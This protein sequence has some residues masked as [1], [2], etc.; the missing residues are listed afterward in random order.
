MMV[1]MAVTVTVLVMGV[2]MAAGGAVRVVHRVGYLQQG[3]ATHGAQLTTGDEQPDTL[4]R[5][6]VAARAPCFNVAVAVGVE[7]K[8]PRRVD[9]VTATE[10][11]LEHFNGGYAGTQLTGGDSAGAATLGKIDPRRIGQVAALQH[12]RR[13]AKQKAHGHFVL[14]ATVEADTIAELDRWLDRIGQLQ[15]IDRTQ[16]LVV[17]STKFER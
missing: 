16:T 14:I 12:R 8:A 13:Q 15:G 6:A 4:D 2:P 9:H 17:L 5:V 7:L 3:S 1:M 11:N 10:E